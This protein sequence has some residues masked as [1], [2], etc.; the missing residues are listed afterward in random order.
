[1]INTVILLDRLFDLWG[2][3]RMNPKFVPKMW[4][5]YEDLVDGQEL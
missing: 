3:R 4:E 2:Y 1:M 5:A